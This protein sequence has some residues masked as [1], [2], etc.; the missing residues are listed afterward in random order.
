MTTLN[1]LL[2]ATDLS[3]PSLNAVDRGFLL[4]K[5]RGARYT[6]V[7]ALAIDTP[8]EF[9]L[10]L[11]ERLSA[12]W[13]KIEEAAVDALTHVIT[14]PSRNAGVSASI[15]IERGLPIFAVPAS[16]QSLGADLVLLGAHGD[17]FFQDLLL[18][19]TASRL[20][21][22]SRCPV[23]VVK[24]PAD[25]AY[26]RVLIPVDFSPA[27]EIAIR[28]AQQV[29]PDAHLVLFHV[30][31][32]PFEGKMLYAGVDDELIRRY[33]KEARE[34]A[35]N[36]LRELAGGLGLSSLD[37]TGVVLHGNPAREILDEEIRHGHDLIVMGKHGT[38]LTEELL[39]GSLTKH[40]LA[41]S[42]C[43]VL[44]VLDKRAPDLET[45]SPGRA[46]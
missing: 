34:R 24:R 33:R 42:R 7:H 35:G 36:R 31:D 32:V 38:H 11:G 9:R 2:A 26:R 15:H 28:T 17:G 40:I 3:V 20:L 10:L 25:E 46:P 22:K 29:A 43:D 19:S 21:R 44:V 4:A 13:G 14:D 30:Y 1:H 23:L 41:A 8:E 45:P 16:I 37:Y 6:V 39:L 27:S 5:E 12:V 18:G